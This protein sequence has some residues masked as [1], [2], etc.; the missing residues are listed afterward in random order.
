MQLVTTWGRNEAS[1]GWTE[2]PHQDD[3]EDTKLQPET[4]AITDLGDDQ[5]LLLSWSYVQCHYLSYLY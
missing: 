2:I 5:T 4:G 3:Y 1:S